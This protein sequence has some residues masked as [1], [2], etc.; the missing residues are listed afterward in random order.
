MS[1]TS[2]RCGQKS[3]IDNINFPRGFRKSGDF[4]VIESELLSLYGHT[5]FGL[6]SGLLTPE[7][8]EEEHLVQVLSQPDK[9]STKIELV[10]IKYIKL[11]REPKRF[12]SLN[13]THSY[14]LANEI[15]TGASIRLEEVKK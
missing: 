14:K 11:T 15:T 4:S 12:H 2:F 1:D 9:A 5:L 7:N 6:E 3:F 13:S 10:W 8:I